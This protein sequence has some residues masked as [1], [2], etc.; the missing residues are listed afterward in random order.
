METV[1]PQGRNSPVYVKENYQISRETSQSER[2]MAAL[3]SLGPPPN[4]RGCAVCRGGAG[5]GRRGPGAY[6]GLLRCYL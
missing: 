3:Y 5:P 1:C 4:K 6:V 2:D